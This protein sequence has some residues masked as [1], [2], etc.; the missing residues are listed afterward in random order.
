MSKSATVSAP[1]RYLLTIFDALKPIIIY[2]FSNT[3]GADLA[4]YSSGKYLR[5]FASFFAGALEGRGLAAT[6]CLIGAFWGVFD[7]PGAS[8]AATS[9]DLSGLLGT[10]IS[11]QISP[12]GS[13]RVFSTLCSPEVARTV[14]GKVY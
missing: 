11:N 12:P 5:V 6:G 13:A 9:P 2:P 4:V 3:L 10:G 1:H 8:C 7:S 14:S